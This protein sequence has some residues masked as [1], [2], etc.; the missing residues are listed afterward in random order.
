MIQLINSLPFQVDSDS[1]VSLCK[2]WTRFQD[3]LVILAEIPDAIRGEFECVAEVMKQEDSNESSD[4]G[5]DES[6]NETDESESRPEADFD[7]LIPSGE[8]KLVLTA[9]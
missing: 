8:G 9:R 3:G 2:D 5:T 1:L 6:G 7:S 4:N